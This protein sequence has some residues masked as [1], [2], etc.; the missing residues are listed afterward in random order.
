MS[1]PIE[2]FPQ[3]PAGVPAAERPRPPI[4]PQVKIAVRAMYVGAAASVV[5]IV[6]DI[7]TISA[8]KTAIEKNTRHHLTASQ[9]NASGHVLAIGFAASGLIAAVVWIVLARAC[10]HGAS[11]ARITGTVLFAVA[12]VDTV[13][14]VHAPLAGAV[15]AWAPVSW[16]AGLVAVIFLWPRVCTAF[17]KGQP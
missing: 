10:L 15:R 8:T 3:Y 5:G 1:Q 16:L 7:A 12:T 14:G 13:V 4:P 9:L 6:I 11:W 2:P 17:F